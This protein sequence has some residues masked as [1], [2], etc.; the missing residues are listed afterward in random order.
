MGAVFMEGPVHTVY[1][2][3][4]SLTDTLQSQ[5]QIHIY[6]QVTFPRADFSY[7]H[8]HYAVQFTGPG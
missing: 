1:H 8:L 3:Y 6:N 7:L 2:M 4:A 5:N